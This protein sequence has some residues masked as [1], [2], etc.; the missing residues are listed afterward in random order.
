MRLALVLHLD[1]R[2]PASLQLALATMTALNELYLQRHQGTPRLYDSGAVY[3][4]EPNEHDSVASSEERIA[5]IPEVLRLGWGDCDDL[6]CYLASERR[7]F[8]GIRCEPRVVLES[9]RPDGSH[10]WH[11]VVVH[12]DG[13]IEDPSLVL[14]M[15]PHGESLAGIYPEESEL[16]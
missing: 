2:D 6:A 10:F 14:G 15:N 16:R 7:V 11:V 9:V 12:P 1:G 13:S 3:A 8:D 5:S 4:T